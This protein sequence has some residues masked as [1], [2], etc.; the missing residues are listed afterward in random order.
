[1]QASRHKS[2][3]SAPSSPTSPTPN[4][5]HRMCTRMTW[6]EALACKCAGLTSWREAGARHAR[7]R[8]CTQ[9]GQPTGSRLLMHAA[10]R[11]IFIQASAKAVP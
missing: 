5:L 7:R 9:Q 4:S 3:R 8:H 2:V 10:Q 1:M 11:S 6:K